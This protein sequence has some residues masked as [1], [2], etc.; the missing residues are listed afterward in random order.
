MEVVI[1]TIRV[2]VLLKWFI[3]TIRTDRALSLP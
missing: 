1:I 2:G 3:I